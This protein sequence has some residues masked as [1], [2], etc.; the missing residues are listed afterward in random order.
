[1][2]VI[3]RAQ[4]RL[5]EIEELV[6]DAAARY[7]GYRS[8]RCFVPVLD[9]ALGHADAARLAYEELAERDFVALPEDCEWLFCLALLAELADRFDDRE[10]AVVLYRL[11]EPY[12]A[13]T[14]M[15]AGEASAGPVARYLGILATTTADWA[16]AEGHLD[17][18]VAM[19]TRAGGRPVLALTQGDYARMLTVRG[20]AGDDERAVELRAAG[21]ATCRELGMQLPD[22]LI[23]ANTRRDS[24]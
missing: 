6:R 9:H 13:V 3:R 15:A 1:M 19:S 16:A 10:R 11:L 17:D 12:P 21:E 4:G 8:F 2:F 22:T 14:A 18:A 7:P 23:A 20:E 5:A 24:P